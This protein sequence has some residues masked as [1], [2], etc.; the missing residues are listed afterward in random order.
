LIQTPRLV[1]PDPV[2]E[3]EYLEFERRRGYQFGK[4]QHINSAFETSMNEFDSLYKKL[5][6]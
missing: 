2:T 4:N 6:K 5:A 3:K 1:T